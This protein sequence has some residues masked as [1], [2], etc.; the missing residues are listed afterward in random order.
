[1]LGVVRGSAV[2]QDGASNGLTAPNGP[3]QERVIGAALASAGLGPGDVDV[4]E[5]H[6]TG[7][8]LGDPIEASALLAAYG[9]GRDRALLVG[10]VK[11]NIGHTQA[12]AGVAGVI[13]MVLA[14]RCGVVPASL[15]VDEPS[16]HVDWSS[17]AVELVTEAVEWPGT[18]RP[19]R[20][21][22]SSFGFSGTNAHLILEQPPEA[23]EPALR[24]DVLNG[25]VPWVIS[26]RGDAALRAQAAA[27][28][29]RIG[30]TDLPV[31]D[32]G[33]SL[34]A[35]RSVFEHRAVVVGQSR[36]E[37]LA[38]LEALARNE[39]HPHVV[40]GA[41]GA[42]GPGPVL[43]FPGQGSQWAGMGARLL[44]T[45][46]VFASRIAECEQALS[47]YVDWSLTEVLRGDGAGLSRVDVVQPVLWAVMVALAAVWAEYGVTPAAVVGHSQG[48]I[49][50][51]CVAGALSIEDAAR[52]VAVRSRALRKLSGH[53]AMASLGVGEQRATDLLA[54]VDG[55]EEVGVAAVNGPASTVI[56]GPPEQVAAVVAAAQERAW[57][58]R[59]IDVDYASHGPQVDQITDELDRALAGIEPA[60]APVAFYS[61]VTGARADTATF[62]TAYWITNLR[63]PVRFADAVGALLGDGYRVFIEVAPHPVLSVGMEECFEHAEVAATAVP[64]LRRDEGDLSR[65]ACSLGHAHVS[66][67]R[68]DWA[69][70][71][72]GDP[73]PQVVRL[74]T[75]AFQRERFWLS[76]TTGGPDVTDLGLAPTGHPVLGAVMEPPE[77]DGRVLTGRLSRQTLP[78]LED[79]E[80]LG[81]VLMP[82]AGQLEWV[83][84][85]ADEVGCGVV[86]ELVLQAPM[87]VPDSGA[88]SVQVVV[89]GAEQD[90]RR[91]V[92]VYSRPDAAWVCHAAGVLAP[93]P[94][95]PAEASDGP[96]PPAGAEPIDVSDLYERTAAAGYGYGPAF[97][98]LHAV[99]RH[100]RDLLAEVELPEAV[101]DRDGFGLHPVLLDAALHALS[102]IGRF[103][104]GEV[105]LPFSW[106][107]VSLHAVAATSVR[108]RLSPLGEGLDEGVRLTVT[109]P[110]GAPVLEV[111]SVV[112]R[113]AT[114]EQLRIAGGGEADGLFTVEWTEM[115]VP[116]SGDPRAEDWAW[117]RPNGAR[118]GDA[119]AALAD[120]ASMPPVVLA[121]ATVVE[122]VLELVRDWLAQAPLDDS[123]LVIVTDGARD[124]TDPMGSAIGG[125][126]RCAQLENPGRFLL[127]DRGTVTETG[128]VLT[129]VRW[130]M[131]M[132]EPQIAVSEGRVLV[133]RL[134]RAGVASELVAPAGE[135][136]WRLGTRGAATLEDVAVVPCPEVLEP[137][138]DGQV[139]V[140]V[141]AA[142]INFRD[143][144]IALGMYPDEG[145]F[146]GSEGA[147]VVAG[148]GP[149]VTG[150]AVGDRVFG[151]FEGA[152]GPLAVAD[153]RMVVP[154]PESWDLREAAGVPVAFL[155]AW[156]GLVDLGGLRAGESVLIH[157][158]T[159][160]VGMAAVRIA[161]HLGAEVF[162][163]AG[164]GKQQVLAEMGIDEAHRASS[165][166]L[167][168]E[169]VVRRATGGRGVDVV[170]N[171]LAGEFTDASLRL[172]AGGGRFI[173]M[174]K[175]DIRRPEGVTYRAFDLVRDA[176]PDRVGEMLATLREL[177]VSG[178]L[179]PLPVRAWPLA[180]AR[181]AFRFMSQARH[182][183]KLV[184]EVPADIDSEGTV[185]VTGGTGTLGAM[186]AEH[187]VRA[188]GMR[189][190][191]LVGRRG[192][193]APGAEELVARLGG[194]G[195]HVQVMAADVSDRAAVEH[196]VAG[197]DP[198]HPLTGVVHA[199]GVIDDGLVTSLTPERF[200]AVWRA[201]A[202]AAAN[203][204][205]VTAGL[206]L[207]LF[208]VFSSAAAVLGSP[209]QANYAAANA[210]CDALTRQRHATGLPG[211]SIGWGL[212]ESVSGMTGHVT[213][214]DLARMRRD[215]FT[216][217][218]DEQGLALLDAA[219]RHGSP[220]L[221][222]VD[223]DTRALA[224][225]PPE[226]VPAMLRA[227][228]AKTGGRRPSAASGATDR[229]SDLKGRLAGMSVTEQHRT[230][231]TL[232]G[233]HAAT[234]LGHRDPGAVRA[235]TPFKELGFDSLTAVELR[236]RLATATGLRLPAALIFDYPQADALADHLRQRLVPDAA[237]PEV[238]D[239]VN[240]VLYE[241]GRIENTLSGLDLDAEARSSIAKRLTGL[242]A[243][244]N[245]GVGGGSAVTDLDLLES[246][247][248][249]E[250]F[251]LID[252]EL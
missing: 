40:A 102:L 228:T 139:R 207:G 190:L 100:G 191:V 194:L 229:P 150:V 156:Y 125:L 164:P 140:E 236:N 241:L 135:R 239:A 203:L 67:L 143:V 25:P 60:V 248:D 219:H 120:G 181:E 80:V 153:A 8:T 93:E 211:V 65:I 199:A 29:E 46:P 52:I 12:A 160:G 166:D 69:P 22:V 15:H 252:R 89:G 24:D 141:H 87:A 122:E 172:L 144:L 11:S 170:L 103:G 240:P 59:M 91:E 70:W 106:S 149:G 63:R 28:A 36:E 112:L 14:M 209:G 158:A 43:V 114:A 121:E 243:S 136:A 221:V 118:P 193:D 251:E 146:R 73:A 74:P 78:W 110:A 224:A 10:S 151:L 157:A 155:T 154:V 226:I 189:R 86:D 41:A 111:A 161:R 177:F 75:Y 85:A 238:T 247:S 186:V 32:V 131:D 92:R 9:R 212:W 62:D 30:D 72:G 187:L 26:A 27:L 3:S 66:G 231:L 225:R 5:A 215:G 137:L 79:H 234:V 2:N 116:P 56:S 138:G 220:H 34:I 134:V 119:L 47:P 21:G 233:S 232:V 242:L 192:P 94:V 163:T 48:E 180:R 88:L 223:L 182:T 142:G 179:R 210:Y 162:A 96:W 117:L 127:L 6:G 176:G 244:L 169:D 245:E 77:G 104:A 71:F 98:G 237:E 250:M 202:T 90:G 222:A 49:A 249:D 205:A 109:D 174:G 208:V 1:M 197:I 198:A 108:V 51:A 13:K 159:G 42:V 68:V 95:R 115:P 175:T 148:V 201:K 97:Q 129:A 101:E 152:F 81:T 19:R 230:L 235:D 55:V 145:V 7:T 124:G 38:A 204:H 84:R 4:V 54:E 57:R 76:G 45:S 183:G 17:G 184:L 168:F 130:A 195:A 58:G 167:A 218:R 200:A 105:W 246:A 128:R 50:A 64:T 133:P 16:R 185:I 227:L 178:R 196:L 18:D 33:W 61:T 216:P 188:W 39:A 82:G 173:E 20:A 171:A 147:G 31:A 23:D 53:G 113:P 217:L 126:V 206:R 213:E 165:R 107:G 44:E 35:T 37:S 132:D 214:A 123:R 83:L 99:W